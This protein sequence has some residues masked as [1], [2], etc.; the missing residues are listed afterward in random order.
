MCPEIGAPVER[1]ESTPA[2]SDA[3]TKAKAADAAKPAKAAKTTKSGKAADAVK[4]AKAGK[5]SKVD[6]PAKAEKSVKTDKVGTGGRVT[7]TNLTPAERRTML[8]KAMKK[9][10]ATSAGAARTAD[11]IAKKSGLTRFDVYGLCYHSHPLV[12]DK[13]VKIAKIEGVHGLSYYLTAS[14]LK[15]E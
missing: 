14:G 6:K 8:L 4:P 10:G 9:L 1:I 5:P 7:T 2:V 11:E 3:S 12:T 15:A 13:L